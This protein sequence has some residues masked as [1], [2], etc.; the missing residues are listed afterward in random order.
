MLID[1]DKFTELWRLFMRDM[2]KREPPLR[3]DELDVLIDL[4]TQATKVTPPPP[5]DDNG[6]AFERQPGMFVVEVSI[7]VEVSDSGLSIFTAYE[8]VWND[9]NKFARQLVFLLTEKVLLE[10]KFERDKLQKGSAGKE[11]P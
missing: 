10:R 3:S 2:Q 4:L 5:P 11:R 6:P 1:W 7:R 8:P 9:K